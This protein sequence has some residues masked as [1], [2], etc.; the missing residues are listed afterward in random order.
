LG[1][2]Y[3]PNPPNESE[4]KMTRTATATA[5]AAPVSIALV[6]GKPDLFA[7]VLDHGYDIDAVAHVRTAT[8]S[9]Y[10]GVKGK[11]VSPEDWAAHKANVKADA[12]GAQRDLLMSIARADAAGAEVTVIHAIGATHY[13]Q[14]LFATVA[15]PDLVATFV[16]RMRKSA[17]ATVIDCEPLESARVATVPAAIAATGAD[18]L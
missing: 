18:V 2:H 4:T 16:A 3:R 1:L 17:T 5:K 6:I 15:D 8:P 11:D 10:Y 14:D 7:L 9:P 12:F 13:G